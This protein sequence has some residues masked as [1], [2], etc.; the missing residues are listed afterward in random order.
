MHQARFPDPGLTREQ[1]DLT[2]AVRDPLAAAE[3]QLDFLDA[4]D[5]RRQIVRRGES[6]EPAAEVAAADNTP[7]SD[8]LGQPFELMRAEVLEGEHIADQAT[9]AVGHDDAVRRHERLQAHGHDRRGP[10]DLGVAPGG[11]V[12]QLADDHQTGRDSDP[13]A[14]RG[15]VGGRQP[16]NRADQLHARPNRPFGIVFMRL[17][18]SEAAKDA[19]AHDPDDRTVEAADLMAASRFV[20]DHH[21]AQVF[22]IETVGKGRRA[23]QVTEEHGELAP[24]ALKRTEARHRRGG[25][26]DLLL[27]AQVGKRRAARGAKPGA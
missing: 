2:L 24:F 3:Q 23:D 1:H 17:R 16:A 13:H 18:M 4:A 26:P 8:R 27:G 15:A 10:D 6:L 9:S 20:R 12:H 25:P 5:Q 11:A 21:L 19:V 14:Q 7:R 22:G